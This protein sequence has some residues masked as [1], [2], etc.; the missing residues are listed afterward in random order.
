MHR[1]NPRVLDGGRKY[2]STIMYIITKLLSVAIP[3]MN[4]AKEKL[5]TSELNLV[6]TLP[7]IAVKLARIKT[8][9]RPMRSARTPKSTPKTD[10]T[11]KMDCPTV[12]F[13]ALSQTQFN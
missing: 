8:G 12:D 2:S 3:E 6:A 7:S 13:Q 5:I 11:K 1:F 9:K 4:R 10:P